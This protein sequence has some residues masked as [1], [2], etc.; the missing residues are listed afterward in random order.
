[1]LLTDLFI[2]VCSTCFAIEPRT[3]YQHR[4]GTTNNWL[5]PSALITNQEYLT[6]LAIAQSYGGI[7]LIEAPSSPVTLAC[8]ELA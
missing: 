1:M 2:M 4:N 7:L 5:E 6:G 8:V 3:N